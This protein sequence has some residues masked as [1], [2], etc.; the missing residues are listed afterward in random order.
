MRQPGSAG[1]N[2][3]E[4]RQRWTWRCS[5][6]ETTIGGWPG[7]SALAFVIAS[8]V[9]GDAP[10]GASLGSVARAARYLAAISGVTNADDRQDPWRAARVHAGRD[11]RASF[12]RAV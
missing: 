7:P 5:A 12:E 6:S 8:R 10:S 11:R 4:L 3:G 2:D 9:P 1:G